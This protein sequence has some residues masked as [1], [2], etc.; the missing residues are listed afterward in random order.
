MKK[1]MKKIIVLLMAAALAVPGQ[2]LAGAA[3][4]AVVNA[5]EQETKAVELQSEYFNMASSY[6]KVVYSKADHG[7]YLVKKGDPFYSN[8]QKFEVSFYDIDSNSY[9]QKTTI[10]RAEDSFVNDEGIY[11]IKTENKRLANAIEQNGKTYTYDCNA[12]LYEYVFET[13]ETKEITLD[14]MKSTANFSGFINALG[15]DK[16]LSLI[17]I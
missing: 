7:F 4:M 1:R 10:L 15:V 16:K 13:G 9:E 8:Q 6:E 2:S 17:H 14:S 11:Y 12:T 3:K 5:Q